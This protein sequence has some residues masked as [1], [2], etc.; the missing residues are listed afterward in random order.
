MR[1]IVEH[2]AS[3]EA[4]FDKDRAKKIREHGIS[5]VMDTGTSNV[6]AI[7]RQHLDGS[8]LQ[9]VTGFVPEVRFAEGLQKTIEFYRSHYER[10]RVY[11]AV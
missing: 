7:S 1:L 3:Y 11:A 10:G 4:L 8:K 5:I 6:V 2:S 9:A